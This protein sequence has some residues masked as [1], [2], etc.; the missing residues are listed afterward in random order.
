MSSNPSSM[1]PANAAQNAPPR[2]S[3]AIWWVLGIFCSVIVLVIIG[4]VVT[5]TYFIRGI[6]GDE[7]GQKVEVTTPAGKVTL[8]A[9]DSVKSVGLPIYP[10][11]ELA[12][13]GGGIELTAPNDKSVAVTGVSYRTS[14]SP[15]KVD[16]WYRAK[17][18]PDFERHLPGDR[19]GKWNIQGVDLESG[20][21]AYVAQGEGLM[22][23][24]AIKRISDGTKIGMAR[25]GKQQAQ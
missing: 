13:S 3:N 20:D 23:I 24:V 16:A 2:R 17:L 12:E 18:G 4:G 22:R 19:A 15:D 10:G 25:M 8:H 7:K 14:D 21:I 5:A 9:T 1:S 11:A 6:H